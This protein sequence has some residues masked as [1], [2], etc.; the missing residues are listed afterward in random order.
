MLNEGEKNANQAQ[1]F[2]ST[3]LENTWPGAIHRKTASIRHLN[4]PLPAVVSGERRRFRHSTAATGR[5][6]IA[7]TS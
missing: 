6:R 5:E 4:G 3:S 1:R 7:G 2:N